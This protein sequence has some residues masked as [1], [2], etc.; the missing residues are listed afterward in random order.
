MYVGGQFLD[1]H[2]F[3]KISTLCKG[4]YEFFCF[5]VFCESSKMRFQ[6]KF[7]ANLFDSGIDCKKFLEDY[8]KIKFKD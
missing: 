2:P 1:N 6:E 7:G 8:F 5:D 3:S 4:A